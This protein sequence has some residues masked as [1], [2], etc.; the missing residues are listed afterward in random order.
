M[1]KLLLIIIIACV[2]FMIVCLIKHRTDLIINFILRACLGTAGIYLLDLLLRSRGYNISVGI[3]G[4]TVL[5][6]GLLG[7]PG[8]LLLYGLA[9]Y[10][11]LK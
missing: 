9:I 11:F 6:N 10:Y 7:F 2:V 3:N 1:D 5:A 8:F 4:I